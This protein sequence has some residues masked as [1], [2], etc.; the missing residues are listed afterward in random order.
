MKQLPIARLIR[1]AVSLVAAAAWFHASNH[2]AIGGMLP[3]PAPSAEHASCHSQEA[4]AE[5]E[6]NGDCA[7]LSCCKSLSAPALAVAKSVIGYD[8]TFSVETD[9]LVAV[10]SFHGIEHEAP[11]AELDTGPPESD[12]FAESVL[13]RSLLAHAP[14]TA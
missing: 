7:D 13:Q 12:S 1:A 5:N 10:T 3:K 9:Y 8:L 11:I 14:P 6:E 4:P 2:C